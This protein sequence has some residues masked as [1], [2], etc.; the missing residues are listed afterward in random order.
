MKQRREV[1]ALRSSSNQELSIIY[2][3]EG[4]CDHNLPGGI[5]IEMKVLRVRCNNQWETSIYR[6]TCTKEVPKR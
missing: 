4:S 3:K 6:E 2:G 1:L 5:M